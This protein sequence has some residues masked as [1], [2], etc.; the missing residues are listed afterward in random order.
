[1]GDVTQIL[2]LIEDGHCR[3][4]D[5]LLPVV[6]EE[7]RKLA[8]HRLAME[9]PGHTLTPTG[10][11]HE[12]YLRLVDVERAQ[13]FNGRGHFFAAAAEAMRRI[14]IESARRKQAQKRKAVRSDTD[15]ESVEWHADSTPQEMLAIDEVLDRLANEDDMAAQLVKLRVFAGFS[16]DEAAPL[17]GISRSSAYRTWKYARAWLTTELQN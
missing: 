9:K 14:M 10:L 16:I 4:A 15:P 2:Q 7:L 11:V 5:A 3:A 13:Q 12:A 8:A 6:Y 1:M 17:L